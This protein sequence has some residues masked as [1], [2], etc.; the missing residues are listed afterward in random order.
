MTGGSPKR[1][2]E[3]EFQPRLD[4]QQTCGRADGLRRTP[5]GAAWPGELLKQRLPPCNINGVRST[6]QCR[7]K[8]RLTAHARKTIAERGISAAW[9]CPVLA[10]PLSIETDKEDP[11]L[12]QALGRIPEHGDRIL[13]VKHRIPLAN[14]RQR[15]FEVA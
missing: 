2:G 9:I 6:D 8:Y 14:L 3:S 11:G 13:R 10:E 1:H 7:A 12:L 15:Q 4:R 5:T